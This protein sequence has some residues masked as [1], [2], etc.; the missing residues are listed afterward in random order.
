MNLLDRLKRTLTPN[1]AQPSQAPGKPATRPKADKR[2][3]KT[4]QGAR[5]VPAYQRFI[6]GPK[7]RGARRVD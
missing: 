4:G 3:K 5:E 2:P 1:D 7:R 6:H